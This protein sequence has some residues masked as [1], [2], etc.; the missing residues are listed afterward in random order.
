MELDGAAVVRRK[1]DRYQNV[2]AMLRCYIE[3]ESYGAAVVRRCCERYRNV[4][5]SE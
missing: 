2:A 4:A 3:M 5:A 1:C